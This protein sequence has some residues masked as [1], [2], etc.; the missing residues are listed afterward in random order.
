MYQNQIL[1]FLKELTLI[2]EHESLSLFNLLLIN[3][4]DY[5]HFNKPRRHSSIKPINKVNKI[6]KKIKRLLNNP[7]SNIRG[8]CNNKDNSTS[9]IKN[10]ITIRKNCKEKGKRALSLGSNPHSKGVCCLLIV[11]FL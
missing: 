1:N 11:L 9:N 8:I 10:N 2:R 7:K 3:I 5:F 6:N 4:K